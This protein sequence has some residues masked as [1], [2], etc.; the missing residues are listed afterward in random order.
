MSNNK[1]RHSKKMNKPINNKKRKNKMK[2]IDPTIQECYQISIETSSE[3]N[4]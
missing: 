2:M 1:M 3:N 4:A